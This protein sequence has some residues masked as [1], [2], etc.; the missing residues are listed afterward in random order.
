MR[1]VA[2]AWHRFWFTPVPATDLAVSRIVFFGG[3][4]LF[5]L[6][7]HFAIWSDVTPALW[8]PIWL[9]ERFNLPVLSAPMILALEIVWKASLVTSAIGLL[10]P[11]SIATS[12]VLGTYLLGLPHNF[13]QTYHFDAVLVLAFWILAFS[14][15]GDAYSVDAAMRARRAGL[16]PPPSG[17]YRWPL[18]LVLVALS[19]VFFAAGFAKLTRTGLE[20]ITSDHLGLLLNRVQYHISDADPLVNWGV[21]LAGLPGA[22]SLMALTTVVIETAYPVALFSRRLRAPMVIAGV[23]LIVSIRLLMGPTFEHFLLINAFWVP[24]ERVTRRLRRPVPAGKPLGA[25]SDL[26]RPATDA[27]PATLAGAP[28]DVSVVVPTFNRA[29]QLARLLDRLLE[30]EYSGFE[31]EILVVDNNS[32][33]RT[34]D[35]VSAAVRAD[36]SGRLRYA[37]EP[38][39][40]VSY[41]RNT[42]IELTSAPIIVFL[43]DDGIPER[44]WLQSFK[45]AFDAHPEADCIGGRVKPRWA[46]PP[47]DWF[48]NHQHA[49]PLALQDRP[50]AAYVD[51]RQASACLLTANLGFRRAV[52]E[53]IGGFSPHYRRGQ[54]RELEMR[55]WR[56]GMH[57]LYVPEMDVTVDVPG[58]RLERRYHRRWHATTAHYHALMRYRDTVDA[59]GRLRTELPQTRRLLGMPLFM[60]REWL[61]HAAGWMWTALTCRR[62]ERFFHETR[63][64]YY[65]SFFLTRC[66][67]PNGFCV[68]GPVLRITGSPEASMPAVHSAIASTTSPAP[69][70][71]ES[72]AS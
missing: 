3:L 53:V 72:R 32:S 28:A 58:A 35:V 36:G 23:G 48:T 27:T 63:L 56:A 62:R 20:W 19:F 49:G 66:R 16:A 6:P 47:P 61:T 22:A 15:A 50:G 68:P 64:W 59:H 46:E 57:G 9:F 17:E 52:F 11:V 1:R 37:F 71:P 42:G 8:Q 10:T 40:G 14:R 54:D 26:M 21:V 34:R 4:A 55:M 65:A 25:V 41:A 24:W 67:Y 29:P 30:Q 5:Y 38:R 39:Q 44:T 43:D 70:V 69:L 60:Y 2:R 18:Q 12:A 45:E 51:A 33:D 13:G 31:W 7:Q